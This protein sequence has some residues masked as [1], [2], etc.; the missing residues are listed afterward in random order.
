MRELSAVTRGLTAKA[1]EA[2]LHGQMES[3]LLQQSRVA[4]EH[5]LLGL[6]RVPEAIALRL[7]GELGADPERVRALLQARLAV[8][9]GPIDVDGLAQLHLT[10]AAQRVLEIARAE[11]EGLACPHVSTPYLLLGLLQ[12]EDS[13]A[14]EVLRDF[15]VTPERV[16]SLVQANPRE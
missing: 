13:V 11:A 14:G 15:G 1:M 3:V 9:S 12:V 7:L 8:G 2:V 6:L 16:R 4:P 5:L 10:A